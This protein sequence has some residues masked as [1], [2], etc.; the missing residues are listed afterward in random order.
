[1]KLS[2]IALVCAATTNAYVA[3]HQNKAFRP[4]S[5]LYST[6]EA[7]KMNSRKTK[8]PV[9]AEVCETTGV[10]LTRFMNEVATLNPE[11]TELTTLF[12]AIDTA[13]YVP[14]LHF[15]LRRTCPN[16]IHFLFSLRSSARLS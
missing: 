8:A 3:H 11:L 1:M 6:V 12:G 5:P 4:T 9:F 10:T 15:M 2:L 7:P 14:C 13:W 16:K